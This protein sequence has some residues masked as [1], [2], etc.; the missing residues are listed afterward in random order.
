[1]S[2]VT[3][4]GASFEQLSHGE[5]RKR[6]SKVP[7][8][9]APPQAKP[10]YESP[11]R[12]RAGFLPARRRTP[13]CVMAGQ[14]GEGAAKSKAAR[15]VASQVSFARTPEPSPERRGFHAKGA[16]RPLVTIDD[17]SVCRR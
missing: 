16:A 14:I 4:V 9:G 10:P 1:V 13:A 5:F 3:E 7:S 2:L 6:H 12:K 8:S 17:S 15:L 11:E